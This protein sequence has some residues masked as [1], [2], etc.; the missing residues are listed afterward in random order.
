MEKNI[1]S[2]FVQPEMATGS[3]TENVL[4]EMA[5]NMKAK[6]IKYYGSFMDINHLV[7]IG[8]VLD[9][10]FKLR[11]V[12]H[13]WKF[14]GLDETEVKRRTLEIKNLL[15]ALYDQVVICLK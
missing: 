3:D 11:N 6:Y 13:I 15:M 2:L 7:I 12:T 14:E 9:A 10:R 5:A 8:L 4:V 1:N